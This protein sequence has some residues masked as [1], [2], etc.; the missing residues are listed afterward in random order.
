VRAELDHLH[1]DSSYFVGAASAANV[2][3]K[4]DEDG[5]RRQQRGCNWAGV[6]DQS[7]VSLMGTVSCQCS[8]IFTLI[9]S[10]GLVSRKLL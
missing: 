4:V 5:L 10:A 2:D 3:D 8:V 7:K 1:T 9:L 6:D